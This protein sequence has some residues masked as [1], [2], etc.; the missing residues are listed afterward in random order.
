MFPAFFNAKPVPHHYYLKSQGLINEQICLLCLFLSTLL[1]FPGS[2]VRVKVSWLHSSI[3]LE[4]TCLL[5]RCWIIKSQRHGICAA[6]LQ[7]LALPAQEAGW[8]HPNCMENWRSVHQINAA[9]DFKGAHD[10][11][12]LVQFGQWKWVSPPRCQYCQQA[13]SREQSGV[14]KHVIKYCLKLLYSN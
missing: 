12:S 2:V 4:I 14:L 10:L 8:A 5:W 13:F 11:L 6:L 1:Q 9:A 3:F 7:P